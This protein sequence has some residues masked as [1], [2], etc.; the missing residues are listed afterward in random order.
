[1]GC[2]WDDL[3]CSTF[4]SVQSK[5]TSP[6]KIISTNSRVHQATQQH[7]LGT[8][9][10]LETDKDRDEEEDELML[11]SKNRTVKQR[12]TSW[13][14]ALIPFLSTSSETDEQPEGKTPQTEG[15][16]PSSTLT[17]PAASKPSFDFIDIVTNSN[18]Q[19]ETNHDDDDKLQNTSLSEEDRVPYP[20]RLSPVDNDNHT[21][22]EEQDEEHSIQLQDPSSSSF[23]STSEQ[24]TLSQALYHVLVLILLTLLLSLVVSP[25]TVH[26][27]PSPDT[28]VSMTHK[29][30]SPDISNDLTL[31]I[32][33]NEVV[34]P[35]VT[36]LLEEPSWD[37]VPKQQN[38]V[39]PP[40]PRKALPSVFDCRVD[41]VC[42]SDMLP[43]I[44]ETVVLGTVDDKSH[45][46]VLETAS[47]EIPRKEEA[48]YVTWMLSL[49]G[50]DVVTAAFF[51]QKKGAELVRTAWHNYRETSI[52]G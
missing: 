52:K 48:S 25:D 12:P 42:L 29:L 31:E 10:P 24:D 4:G 1:M 46:A 18:K 50:P 13:Q 11:L 49:V 35:R 16:T 40:P 27:I 20:L 34:L 45:D 51:I 22:L 32:T 8:V 44:V 26:T 30:E 41:G 3:S 38:L 2:H 15:S 6:N 33:S 17:T 7:L 9:R 5:T 19:P 43:T 36:T 28:P 47:T 37:M 21:A 14:R 23:S 39:I